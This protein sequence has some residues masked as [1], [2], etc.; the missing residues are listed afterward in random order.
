MRENEKDRK[1]ERL[2]EIKNKSDVMKN[3]IVIPNNFIFIKKRTFVSQGR[4]GVEG[5]FFVAQK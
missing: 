2:R 3:L 4:R 5:R 1:E